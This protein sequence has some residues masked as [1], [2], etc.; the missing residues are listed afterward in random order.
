VPPLQHADFVGS[1]DWS[2]DG[3]RLLTSSWDHTAV[4]W[5]SRSGERVTTLRG[6]RRIARFARFSPDASLVLAGGD[7]SFGYLWSSKSG[8]LVAL[9]SGH[10]GTLGFGEF[11]RDGRHVVAGGDDA[12]IWAV[13]AAARF[14]EW[15]GHRDKVESIEVSRDGRRFATASRDGTA[16]IWDAE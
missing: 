10:T 15:E 4:V 8:R 13:P 3:T 12:K 16:R 5:D 6:P 9:F 2:P 11:S 7:D 1:I 14:L